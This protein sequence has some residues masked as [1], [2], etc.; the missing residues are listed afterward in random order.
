MISKT[1]QRTVRV[2]KVRTFQEKK[3]QVQRL[4]EGLLS[5]ENCDRE[6]QY[7]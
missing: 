3:Q 4:E 2:S 5:S 6:F 7:G 1:K